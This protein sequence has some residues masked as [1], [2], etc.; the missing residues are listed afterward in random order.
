MFERVE[1]DC[2]ALTEI[3]ERLLAT[4]EFHSVFFHP[5]DAAPSYPDFRRGVQAVLSEVLQSSF[6][7]DVV[8]GLFPLNFTAATRFATLNRYELEGSLVSRLLQG[9]CTESVVSDEREARAV[10]RA[11]LEKALLQPNGSLSGFRLDDSSWS[12]LSDRATLSWSYL[13]YESSR[14]VWWFVC[15][16]DFY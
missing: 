10:V 3:G 9:T 14:K 16:A 13:V 6:L 15:F 5:S 2:P 1:I 7:S 11:I 12:A 8:P 4:G